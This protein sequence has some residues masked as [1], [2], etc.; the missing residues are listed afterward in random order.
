MSRSSG[1]LPPPEK[2][3]SGV[4]V[5]RTRPPLT[6][7]PVSARRSISIS[8]GLP[9]AF[10]GLMRPELNTSVVPVGSKIWTVMSR[11]RPWQQLSRLW[12]TSFSRATEVWRLTSQVAGVSPAAVWLKLPRSLSMALLAG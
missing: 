1:L 7:A 6:G 11:R 8:A 5:T 9:I 10:S 12:S 4:R 3:G 2:S